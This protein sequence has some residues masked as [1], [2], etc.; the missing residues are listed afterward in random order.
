MGKI[1]QVNN[2]DTGLASR[3]KINEAMKTVETDA[4][5]SGSGTVGNPLKVVGS[6]TTQ[7]AAPTIAATVL[8]VDFDSKNNYETSAEVVASANFSIVLSNTANARNAQI[9][10]HITN[11]IIITLPANSL[12]QDDE[13]RW[14]PTPTYQIAVDG[15]TGNSYELNMRKV[16]SK[17]K[18]ILSQKFV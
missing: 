2:G 14:T 7:I 15:L 12:M 1:T 17:L 13:D 10:L 8:G 9:D 6:V 3:T 5:L 18:W 4:T 16:G 11:S